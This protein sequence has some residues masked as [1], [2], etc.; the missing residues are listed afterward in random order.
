MSRYILSILTAILLFS[1]VG[2]SQPRSGRG[3]EKLKQ[4]KISFLS[5]RVNFTSEE[6]QRFW[7]V[8]NEYQEKLNELQR[9]QVAEWLWWTQDLETLP[10]DEIR[11]KL[12]ETLVRK[13]QEFKLFKE[14][15]EKFLEVL[16]VAKV[17]MLYR[18]EN[19]F[20]RDLLK[21]VSN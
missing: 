4:H 20:K 19:Q 8:Y 12:D 11:T 9:N 10:E 1:T 21:R 3:L 15:H 13:E 14:Y 7:P 16:P 2:F 6:A 17:A 18:A 5:A